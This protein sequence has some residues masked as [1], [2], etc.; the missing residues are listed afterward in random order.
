VFENSQIGNDV[1][2]S[3]AIILKDSVI[4]DGT[5]INKEIYK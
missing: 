2:I 1:K 5:I 4:D 3:N